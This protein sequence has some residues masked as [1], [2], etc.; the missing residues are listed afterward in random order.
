[1][2]NKI[3]RAAIDEKYL[4][5]V[6]KTF[7]LYG[8][9]LNSDQ[10]YKDIRKCVDLLLQYHKDGF[11]LLKFLDDAG[12]SKRKARKLKNT[13]DGEILSV[14][15]NSSKYLSGYTR[16]V[17]SHLQT[18]SLREKFNKTIST[19]EEQYHLKM[20]EIEL[21]NRLYIDE[22]KKADIKLAFLPHCLHDLDKDCLAQT[23]GVDYV[24]KRCSKKCF[25]NSVTGILNSFDIKAYIWMSANLRSLFRK[26]KDGKKKIGVLGIACIPELV[27]GMRM[28]MK[29][30]IPV[31]G[32]PLDANRCRRW[33]G[34][35]HK[36]SVNINKLETLLS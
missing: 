34:E 28:C 33:M 1:M 5:L 19:I 17:K 23:D 31:V 9:D 32:V 22:F 13:K 3:F 30:D 24:C 29:Y 6:G 7:S 18:L 35:F 11:R 14:I 20:I 16:P 36:T 12:S 21:V 8:D 15:L 26:L 2:V 25:I 10:F 4:P 27:N